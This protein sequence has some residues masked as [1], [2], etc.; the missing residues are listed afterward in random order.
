MKPAAP[1]RP[2]SRSRAAA[3]LAGAAVLGAA[4]LAVSARARAAER[5]HPPAGRFVTVEGVR[6]RYKEFGRGSPVVLIHGNGSLIEEIEAS[7]LVRRLA[8]AHRVILFDRPGFGYSERPRGRLWTPR[9]QARLIARALEWLQ[10]DAAI[11]YGHS[12]GAQVAAEIAL[13]A[14][15]RVRALVLGAGY[16]YPTPRP[17]VP[18]LVPLA[19]PVIGDVLRH[20]IAPLLM[21]PL[22]RRIYAKL[23]APAPVPERFRRD[24]PHGLVLR[25]RH[26]RA[27]AADTA[28]L[29]PGAWR[30]AARYAE[31]TMPV[32][33]V[34]G[35]GD[36][37]VYFDSHA[38]R[39]HGALPGSRL[40][41]VPGAGHMIHHS[42]VDEVARAIEAA[43][44]S[45]SE[46][47]EAAPSRAAALHQAR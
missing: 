38:R 32:T 34:A 23:F 42:A 21:A 29:I 27:T 46:T 11:L 4:A 1:I 7:G 31:L 22:M 17:D 20:T 10:V 12:L 16:L 37:V 39:L 19:V 14:P 41:G 47:R 15:S 2:S 40:I 43:V 36:E 3:L 25:P 44:P 13:R 18:V 33:I 8:R 30:L 5:R 24:V 6:L 26:L 9:A 28:F 45:P 35:T